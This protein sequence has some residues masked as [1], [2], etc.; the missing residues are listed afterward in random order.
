MEILYV[1]QGFL[2][3]SIGMAVGWYLRARR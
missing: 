1:L 2:L 3:T